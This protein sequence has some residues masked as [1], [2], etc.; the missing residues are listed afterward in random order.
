M[1]VPKLSIVIP[2]YNVEQ[3]LSRCLESIIN[4]TFV[5]YEVIIIDDGSSDNSGK[6]CD[7]YCKEYP[8]IHVYHI[9]NSG[10]SHARNLGILCARGKYIAFVDSDDYIDTNMYE[11]LVK[12][13]ECDKADITICGYK[14]VGTNNDFNVSC[15]FENELFIKSQIRDNVIRQFYGGNTTGLSSL[16]NK[17]YKSSFIKESGVLL[18]EKLIRGEDWWFN[19]RLL[20]KAQRIKFVSGHYYCYYRGNEASIMTKLRCEYYEEWKAAKL[21][22]DK[23]NETYHFTF[24]NDKYYEQILENIHALLIYMA[25]NDIDFEYILR[26]PF[27]Q[28]IIQ[29][30]GMNRFYLKLIHKLNKYTYV[31]PKIIYKILA[32]IVKW[33]QHENRNFYNCR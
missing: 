26:D 19:L 7:Y 31:M 29:Y 32:K 14:V 25:Q 18:D 17:V 6:I 22:L 27:Y 4:Q 15:Q 28:H 8:N 12:T 5:Q 2:V 30:D 23:K 16:W 10:P 13:A 9:S 24:D 3:Y 1:T 21:Y 20:E 33:R 11:E